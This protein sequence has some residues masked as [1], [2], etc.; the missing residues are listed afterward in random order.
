M[1][2]PTIQLVSGGLLALLFLVACSDGVQTA[3]RDG[4]TFLLLYEEHESGVE[5]YRTRIIVTPQWVRMDDGSPAGDYLL[6]DRWERVI[7]SVAHEDRSILVIP[8]RKVEG[9]PPLPLRIDATLE[10]GKSFPAVE[11]V[12]P[13]HY[14]LLVNDRVCSQVVAAKGLLPGAVAA[15]RE[16]RRTLAGQH[17]ENLGKTPV[18][19]LDPC[20][21]SIHVYA[22]GRNLQYGL[23]L[24]EW[25]DSGYGRSLV[26]YRRDYVAD[27]RLFQLPEGYLRQTLSADGMAPMG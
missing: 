19:M 22:P 14:R 13:R 23:P 26:D 4:G 7:Y 24:E 2:R 25:D 3:G 18:E 10:R 9:E 21:L 17:A 11:G 15:L 20:F 1:K 27:P 6:Y 16:F 8:Y 12:E 5:P